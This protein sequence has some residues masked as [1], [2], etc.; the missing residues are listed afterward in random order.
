MMR[1]AAL[2]SS[3]CELGA[4]PID[5]QAFSTGSSWEK[6][7]YSVWAAVLKE[8]TSQKDELCLGQVSAPA[9]PWRTDN[10]VSFPQRHMHSTQALPSITNNRPRPESHMFLRRRHPTPRVWQ[11]QGNSYTDLGLQ[12]SALCY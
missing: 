12:S 2:C 1:I 6:A 4:E 11:Q 3:Y 5:Q 10:T 8:Y 9:L 7:G